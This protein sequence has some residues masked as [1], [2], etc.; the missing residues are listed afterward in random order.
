MTDM[1][2]KNDISPSNGK[3]ASA[4]TP[5]WL[6]AS[7]LLAGCQGGSGTG[8]SVLFSDTSIEE[9]KGTYIDVLTEEVQVYPSQIDAGFDPAAADAR[10]GRYCAALKEAAKNWADKKKHAGKLEDHVAG[11]TKSLRLLD[12]CIPG[13]FW[14][15]GVCRAQWTRVVDYMPSIRIARKEKAAVSREDDGRVKLTVWHWYRNSLPGEITFSWLWRDDPLAEKR[16]IAAVR[17][18]VYQ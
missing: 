7:M 10:L 14:S 1:D 4:S 6:A 18:R 2:D 15:S 12:E 9:V 8:T 3:Q 17:K 5:L 13:K 11:A 16:R